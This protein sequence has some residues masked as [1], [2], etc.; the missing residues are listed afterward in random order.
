MSP[1]F[2]PPGKLS[3]RHLL[4][5]E[6]LFATF[7]KHHPYDSKFA[8]IN[9]LGIP[10]SLRL[11]TFLQGAKFAGWTQQPTKTALNYWN[12]RTPL[13]IPRQFSITT[14][15]YF[16]P[17]LYRPF[18]KTMKQNFGTTPGFMKELDAMM[19]TIEPRVRTVT[20]I[21]RGGSVAAAGLVATRG[22]FSYLF[23]GSVSKAFR[24][25]GLWHSLV[26]ARQLISETQ[27]ANFWITT[28]SNPRI[29]N[30][31]NGSFPMIVLRKE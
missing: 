3:S 4:E 11:K 16:D 8:Y 1:V 22:E 21:H 26:A 29:M 25:R 5:A 28:T 14:G 9:L 15:R 24:S 30:Q 23:C 6:R 18:R 13:N 19:K 20:L 2:P 10:T 31:G 12:V 7:P 17:N 27:G